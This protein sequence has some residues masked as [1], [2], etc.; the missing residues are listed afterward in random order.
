MSAV[1]SSEHPLQELRALASELDVPLCSE[2]CASELDI[3]DPISH[4]RSRF[5]IPHSPSS[6]HSSSSSAASDSTGS[7]DPS[8]SSGHPWLYFSGNSLG[9]QP[10]ST[11]RFINEELEVGICFQ[12]VFPLQFSVACAAAC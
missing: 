12:L 6:S 5:R 4:C 3:R 8:D 11:A 10:R 7:A 1:D 2:A 9:L